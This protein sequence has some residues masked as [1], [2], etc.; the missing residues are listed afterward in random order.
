VPLVANVTANAVVDPDTIRTL[1][2]QQVTGQVRWRETIEYLKAQGVTRVIEIGS[3]KV[4]TGLNKRIAPEMETA[5]VG[6]P[7]DIGF[8]TA[9]AA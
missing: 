7:A 1:L 6:E 9:K 5:N 3:G 4:L 2:V 8:F